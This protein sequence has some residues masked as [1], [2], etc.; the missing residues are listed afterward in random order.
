[1]Q[2]VKD[3]GGRAAA[4]YLGDTGDCVVRAIA[5]ATEMPYQQ[6]YD[7]VNQMAQH[8]RPGAKRRRGRRSSARTGVFK[9]TEKRVMRELGWHWTPTMLVGSGC[10]VHLRDGELPMGRLLVAVSLHS[11][12]VIDGVMHDTHD[13]SR[14]GTRCVYGYWQKARRDS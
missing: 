7:L 10:K 9:P 3:D 1:M 13:P 2:W 14:Q 4:G 8:E 6:V 11:V 12:A 5:I